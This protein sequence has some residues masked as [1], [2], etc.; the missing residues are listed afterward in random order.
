M[1]ASGNPLKSEVL[2]SFDFKKPAEVTASPKDQDWL[3]TAKEKEHL[4]AAR[5]ASPELNKFTRK[6]YLLKYSVI[7]STQGEGF[8]LARGKERGLGC[9]SYGQVK[10][11][12][13]INTGEYVAVKIQSCFNISIVSNEVKWLQERKDLKGQLIRTSKNGPKKHYII[14][15]LFSGVS[16][17]DHLYKE[18]H[19]HLSEEQILN[20]VKMA[21]AIAQDLKNNFH[22]KNLIHN[23]IHFRNIL[24]DEKTGDAKLI[25][26]AFVR[27]LENGAF[28]SNDSIGICTAPEV[29]GKNKW[30]FGFFQGKYFYSKA[31]D[32]HMLGGVFQE[33]LK[34]CALAKD[35]V[36]S[37]L[38]NDPNKRPDID[39][40]IIGL[41][42]IKNELDSVVKSKSCSLVSS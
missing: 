40:V 13:N 37:M 35:I 12:Q 2:V 31:S 18:Y 39:K 9:G 28:N 10:L 33:V 20:R 22:N 14:Q 19:L 29:A 8:A 5:N 7:F 27:E 41:V 11:G 6:Q 17:R 4:L 3:L 21:I 38:D 32:I 16:I 24:F 25:D 34:G 23:D 26:L 15:S 36:Q 42:K 30:F 1:A